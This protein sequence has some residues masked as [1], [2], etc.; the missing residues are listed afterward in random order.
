MSNWKNQTT[1]WYLVHF[2][3]VVRTINI[4][5][6]SPLDVWLWRKVIRFSDGGGLLRPLSTKMKNVSLSISNAMHLGELVPQ[7]TLKLKFKKW[8]GRP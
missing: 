6:L 1:L 7:S 3:L 8:P 2:L 4:L 5:V